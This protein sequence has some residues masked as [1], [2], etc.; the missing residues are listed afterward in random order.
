MSK[1]AT[2]P[3][4]AIDIETTGLDRFSD[5]F[6]AAVA[7]GATSSDVVIE[8]FILDPLEGD[9]RRDEGRFRDIMNQTLLSPEFGGTVVFHNLLFDL[10]FLLR[11]LIPGRPFS[12]L[13]L[14]PKLRDTL[15]A[16]RIARNNK[17]F[18]HVEPSGLKAHSLKYLAMERLLPLV[19]RLDC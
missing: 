4:I 15:A 11:R 8:T 16:S 14:A 19:K 12:S 10:S 2:T 6:S 9:S 7:Y 1:F 5:I 13:D 17:A 18:T 3:L